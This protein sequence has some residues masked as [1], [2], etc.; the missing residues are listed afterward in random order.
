MKKLVSFI[1]L[2]LMVFMLEFNLFRNLLPEAYVWIESLLAFG[3]LFGV[4]A[5]NGMLKKTK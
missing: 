5:W 2:V 3:T 1:I 4:L